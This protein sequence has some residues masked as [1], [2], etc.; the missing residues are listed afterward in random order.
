MKNIN[1]L[2]ILLISFIL[3]VVIVLSLFHITD[4]AT[5]RCTGEDCPICSDIMTCQQTL[6]TV[7]TATALVVAALLTKLFFMLSFKI[8]ASICHE[9]IN[10]V[11]L[12]VKLTN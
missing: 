9:T 4:Q 7:G 11:S 12:K 2:F 6:N 5:H 3:L 1:K 10:L 8:I